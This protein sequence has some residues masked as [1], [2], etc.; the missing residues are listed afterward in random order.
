ME[1]KRKDVYYALYRYLE[2][3][4]EC[5]CVHIRAAQLIAAKPTQHSTL[6]ISYSNRLHVSILHTILQKV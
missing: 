1:A 5:S 3:L 2:T 6:Y 4:T